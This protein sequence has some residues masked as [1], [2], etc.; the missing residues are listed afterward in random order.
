MGVRHLTILV[1]I[2]YFGMNLANW[3]EEFANG[4]VTRH[5]YFQ[6]YVFDN[7]V[8]SDKQTTIKVTC[9]QNLL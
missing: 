6:D 5:D 7:V 4:Y 2:R 9:L 3:M 8:F 1:V